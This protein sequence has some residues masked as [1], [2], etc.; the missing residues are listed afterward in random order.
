MNHRATLALLACATIT[1]PGCRSLLGGSSEDRQLQP[2]RVVSLYVKNQN[3]LDAKIYVHWQ[4]GRRF[5][6]G[7]VSGNG[8][9][10]FSF[11]WENPELRIEI[12]LLSVGGSYFT[13]P[14]TVDSGDYLELVVEPG[15]DRRIRFN[16]RG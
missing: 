5:R 9:D 6:V 14:M 16:R 7:T 8:E 4:S 10:T 15:L 12:E 1:L 3:F 13:H 11:R 2:A